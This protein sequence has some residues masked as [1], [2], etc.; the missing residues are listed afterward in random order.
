LTDDRIRLVER[1][2]IDADEARLREERTSAEDASRAATIHVTPTVEPHNTLPQRRKQPEPVG[3]T[4]AALFSA[5]FVGSVRRA[6]VMARRGVS[7]ALRRAAV[8]GSVVVEAAQPTLS[9][10][11]AVLSDKIEM[12]DAGDLAFA[13]VT[14]AVAI[15]VG[16]GIAFVA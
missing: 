7:L 10:L 5:R 11:G 3:P 16:V 2:M 4:A 6:L 13:A 8:I 15:G 12:S 1:Y 14:V 9:S